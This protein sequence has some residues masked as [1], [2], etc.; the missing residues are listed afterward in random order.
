M[1]EPNLELLMNMVR[2][3]IDTQ[4]ETHEDVREM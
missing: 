4:C 2:K 1:A 3:A